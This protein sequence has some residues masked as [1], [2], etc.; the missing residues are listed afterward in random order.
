MQKSLRVDVRIGIRF[1]LL[2]FCSL[3]IN[4]FLF[5]YIT[6]NIILGGSC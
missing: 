1:V 2:W 5:I 3:K 6:S 4:I